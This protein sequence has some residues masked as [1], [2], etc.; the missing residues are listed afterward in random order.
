MFWKKGYN[1][2][3]MNDLVDTM[4]INRSSI[5]LSYGNKHELFLKSLKD[6]IEQK[7]EQYRSASQKSSEPLEAIKNI[8]KSVTDSALREGDCLFTKSVF[9]LGN[10][11]KDVTQMLSAQTLKAVN[12]FEGLLAEAKQAGTLTSDKDIKALAFFLVSGLT[13]IYNVQILFSDAKL[14]QQT[15]KILMDTIDA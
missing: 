11:D 3:S 13:S 2:T 8:I 5:Y 4:K 10:S 15:A 7:D 1:A 9:E 14:T 6:Y 12:L